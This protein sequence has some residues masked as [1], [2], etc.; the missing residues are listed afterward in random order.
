M[1]RS[2]RIGI[3]HYSCP[4]VVGGVEEMLH[5]HALILHRMGQSVCILAG[6]GEVFTDVFPVRIELVLGSRHTQVSKAH[7]Q[8][9]KGDYRLLKKLTNRILKLLVDWSSNLDVIVAHNVLQ[10]P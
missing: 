6:M 8:S 7:E 10:M 5:Q 1:E 9:R 4:P 3:L 2:L